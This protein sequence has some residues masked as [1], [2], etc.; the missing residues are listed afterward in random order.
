M[1]N[2]KPMVVSFA[3]IRMS[4]AAA[5]HMPAPMAGPLIAAMMGTGSDSSDRKR[6]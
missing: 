5:T 6:A 1:A 4:H 3:A 2:V